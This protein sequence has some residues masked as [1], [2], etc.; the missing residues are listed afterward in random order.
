MKRKDFIRGAGL[1]GISTILPWNKALSAARNLM[2]SPACILIPKET[3]GPFPLDLSANTYYF[4]KNVRETESGVELKLKLKIIGIDNCLP[5]SNVRVNIWHCNKDGLYSGYDNAMNK[6]QAGKTYLRGYQITDANGEVEF[7]TIFPGWYSGRIVHIHFQAYVSSSY[8][9]VS[10]LTFDLTAKNN[11]FLENS[12]I[13]TKGIDPL[14]YNQDNIFS[15]GYQIQLATLEKNQNGSYTSFM[16]VAINGAGTLGIGH[17]EKEN[18][19]NFILGQNFPNPYSSITK[20]PVSL[21]YNSDIKLSVFNLEGQLVFSKEFSNLKEGDHTI[22]FYPESFH[23]PKANYAYQ[24]D[25]V[26]SNGKFSDVK[27]MTCMQ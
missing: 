7:D 13:Y 9:V 10:Q 1:A 3:E 4:R 19:K 2:V 11:L 23:L 24:L 15:D 5:M 12:N 16:E 22:E 20:I 27:L 6:G 8:S 17:I 26:N 14:S 18:S 21:N 25:V